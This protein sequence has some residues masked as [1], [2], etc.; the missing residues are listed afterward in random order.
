M[1][2]KSLLF[3]VYIGL[4]TQK[5][6]AQTPAI[7]SL[8]QLVSRE[9]NPEK[10]VF[11]L[12]EIVNLQSEQD[13]GIAYHTLRAA[14]TMAKDTRYLQAFDP[15]YEAQIIWM[16][17][18]AKTKQL[19][20]QAIELLKDY[21][22]PKALQITARA[23]H[24]Y[25]IFLQVSGRQD[26][27]TNILLNKVIPA[28][29]QIDDRVS[30]ASAYNA[31]G[32]VYSNK[33]DYQTALTYFKQ[34]I[35]YVQGNEASIK[36]SMVLADANISSARCVFYLNKDLPE[37]YTY[38]ERSR[39]YLEQVGDPVYYAD[40]YVN[41]G[42]YYEAQAKYEQA[43]S[44]FDKGLDYAEKSPTTVIF[45]VMLTY[46]KAN[47]LMQLK[48][49]NEARAIL[50]HLLAKNASDFTLD[51]RAK[52]LQLRAEIEAGMGNYAAAY[53]SLKLGGEM[54]D[55]LHKLQEKAKITEIKLKYN[56][57]EQENKI[58]KLENVNRR[59]HFFM[60]L[61]GLFL[62]LSGIIFYIFLRHR[63]K[64][65]LQQLKLLA[66]EKEIEV[67]NALI[68][69]EE[70]ER[71]RLARE[72]HDGLGGTFAG[73]KLKLEIAV[74]KMDIHDISTCVGLLDN[75]IN[76]FR[77][78]TH[79]LVPEHLRNKGLENN[80]KDFC[81]SFRA[82]GIEF[83]FYFKGLNLLHSDEKELIIFRIIQ[84]LVTNAVK[85]S[86]AQHILLNCILE[87]RL[88]LLTVED[89]GIGF[90]PVIEKKGMGLQNIK[91]R[92]NMLNGTMHIDSEKDKGTVIN[93]EIAL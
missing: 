10:K 83:R 92:I 13:T 65:N 84:E 67:K 14:R 45:K 9:N 21:K 4:F 73:I 75:A 90:D 59:N 80:V 55:S 44:Q 46:E 32:T 40:Y 41:L 64:R 35:E 43:L 50:D 33:E 27:F 22:T 8:Q 39:P 6:I 16:S 20:Q 29:K 5:A 63:K 66:S 31:V 15:F 77:H 86:K 58:L 49:Y 42:R 56:D 53:Q 28:F 26:E 81:D 52:T 11:L 91:S 24:N 71:K 17:D 37:M 70:Q 60:M 61:I 87:N 79:R 82:S 36:R 78:T 1:E 2:I 30:V 72:L 12:Y 85:H 23:W 54:S 88:L 19:Y 62:Y 34:A 74:K 25:G 57:S 89:D 48:Q 93:I 7:D 38:L 47:V 3:I 18:S 68:Y 69:G 76:E 51:N